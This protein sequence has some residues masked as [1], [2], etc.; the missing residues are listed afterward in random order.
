MSGPVSN[1]SDFAFGSLS[2]PGAKQGIEIVSGEQNRTWCCNLL[3]SIGPHI[4]FRVLE[5][6]AGLGFWVCFDIDSGF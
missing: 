6:L 5:G 4:G 2:D 3:D 1:L